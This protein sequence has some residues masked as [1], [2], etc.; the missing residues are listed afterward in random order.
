MD[1]TQYIFDNLNKSR[2]D[3]ISLNL[4]ALLKLPVFVLLFGNI[5]YALIL[6]LRV[7]ILADTFESNAGGKIKTLMYGYLAL[8]VVGSL[9]SLLFIVLG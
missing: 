3:N 4:S 9:I 5:L 1:E 2:Q 7:R 6:L 8:I